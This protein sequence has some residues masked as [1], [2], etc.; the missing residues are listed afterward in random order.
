MQAGARGAIKAN[1]AGPS[2]P[3]GPTEDCSRDGATRSHSQGRQAAGVPSAIDWRAPAEALKYSMAPHCLTS[4]SKNP[5]LPGPNDGMV[6]PER[7]ALDW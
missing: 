2:L 4:P 7:A 3:G 1:L 5:D 6:G